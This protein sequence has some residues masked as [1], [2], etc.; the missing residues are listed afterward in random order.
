MELI[1]SMSG[2]VCSHSDTYFVT[3]RQTGRVHTGRICYPSDQAPTDAQIEARTRFSQRAHRTSV[4][5]ASNKP[6]STQP[7]GTDLYVKALAAFRGQKKIGSFFGYIASRIKEDGTIS[8][9]STT[10]GSNGG[11]TGGNGGG[12]TGGGDLG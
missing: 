8:F 12:S 9:D 6:S 4:W 11:S 3:N 5:L 1:A 10:S 2:K 7:M